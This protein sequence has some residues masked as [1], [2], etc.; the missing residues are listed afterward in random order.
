MHAL[1]ELLE[2][3]YTEQFT[4]LAAAGESLYNL[5]PE[6]AEDIAHDILLASLNRNTRPDNSAVF[7]AAALK[8]AMERRN[9]R[10]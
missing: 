8:H 2:H 9:A 4:L 6:E 5:P 10:G 7:F 3:Y 1:D